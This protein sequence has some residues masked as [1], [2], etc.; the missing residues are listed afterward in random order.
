[1]YMKRL[2]A[3]LILACLC[4]VAGSAWADVY[5]YRDYEGRVYLTDTPMKGRYTLV[6]RYRMQTRRPAS[7]GGDSLAAMQKRRQRYAPLIESAARASELRPELVHAV[8]RA[9][10]AYRADAVS[11]KGAR[12]LMQL[13]PATAERFGVTDLH[14]PRQNL[15]GGTRYLRELL[16]LFDNDLRLA[17]AAYNAGENAVISSGRR[18]PPYPETQRYV[19]KVLG[20]Y[21]LNRAAEQLA[22]R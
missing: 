21:K 19:E 6:K 11:E 3:G 17:L 20:F 13:M 16:K 9:E 22:Q 18:V 15:R 2:M 5:K 1:M 7:K 10:S 12:G 8:V 4:G 14:D